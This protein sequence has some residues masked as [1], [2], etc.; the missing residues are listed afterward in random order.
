MEKVTYSYV[1]RT[2][3]AFGASDVELSVMNQRRFTYKTVETEK[4]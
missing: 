2:P 4:N 1:G 3:T